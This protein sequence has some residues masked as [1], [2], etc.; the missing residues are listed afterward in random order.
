MTLWVT[1]RVAEAGRVTV[2]LPLV[3]TKRPGWVRPRMVAVRPLSLGMSKVA[4]PPV[5][6]C[7][8]LER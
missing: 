4:S 7:S 6:L 2:A 5:I 1:L 3:L 8:T